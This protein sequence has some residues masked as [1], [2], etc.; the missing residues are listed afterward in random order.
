M[1]PRRTPWGLHPHGRWSRCRGGCRGLTPSQVCA[2]S[3]WSSRPGSGA[4]SRSGWMRPDLVRT[5]TASP[6]VGFVN[7]VVRICRGILLAPC[8]RQSH[9]SGA[10]GASFR[11]RRRS[12]CA[13]GARSRLP[14]AAAVSPGAGSE[15][16]PLAQA[17]G[18]GQTAACSCSSSRWRRSWRG[19]CSLPGETADRDPRRSFAG[20][21]A[22]CSWSLRRPSSRCSAWRGRTTARTSGRGGRESPITG[23][24][25]LAAERGVRRRLRWRRCCRRGPG[26]RRYGRRPRGR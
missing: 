19:V 9:C 11:G 16:S 25:S 4:R 13:S 6:R 7:S 3:G 12:H 26:T 2:E 20:R 22:S 14:S 8:G 21:R 10:Q 15:R 5:A 18:R 24:I 1:Y 17:S 23:R